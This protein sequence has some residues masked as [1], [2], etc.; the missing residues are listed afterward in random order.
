M[1]HK[2]LK[3]VYSQCL[4]FSA[5]TWLP[6]VW[7]RMARSPMRISSHWGMPDPE[8]CLWVRVPDRRNG[9]SSSAARVGMRA[10]LEQEGEEV[11]KD[12]G[13]WSLGGPGPQDVGINS[14]AEASVAQ[15]SWLSKLSPSGCL[16]SWLR[17]C[18][19]AMISCRV[20]HS[21]AI[22]SF[23]LWIFLHP[24]VS[25]HRRLTGFGQC[26]NF[27]LQTKSAFGK[28]KNVCVFGV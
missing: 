2:Y 6:G 11:G 21:P 17:F 24:N 5:A 10:R 4:L 27:T 1:S 25:P 20:C 3:T 26:S 18:S 14:I 19:L 15:F 7:A 22:R 16:K 12:M 23:H 9:S 8:L 13:P 28:K